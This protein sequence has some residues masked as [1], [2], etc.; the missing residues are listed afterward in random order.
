MATGTLP[1]GFNGLQYIASYPDLIQSLG[2]NRAAGEQH[3]LAVGQAE[4]RATDT[5]DLLR[6]LDNNPDVEAA[7]GT[8][9]D[10]ATIHYIRQGF[11]EGRTD[12]PPAGLPPGFNGLQYIASYPDLIQSLGADRFAGE[13]HYLSCGQAEGRAP[14]TFDLARYL[15]NNPDV[16]AAFGSNS[17]AATIHYIEQGFFEGRTDDPPAGPAAPLRRP[18]IH[19]VLSR[20]DPG[21]RRRPLRRRAALPRRWA[22]RGPPDRYLRRGALPGQQPRPEGRARYQQHRPP[23]RT[24]SSSGFAE[25]RTDDP[26]PGLP[27][28]FSGLQ[29]I[30]SYPDLIEAIGADRL[31][32]E[33]HYLQAGQAEG[34]AA[35]HLQHSAIPRE[36]PGRRGRVRQQRRCGHRYTSS[37]MATS[38]AARMMRRQPAQAA[39]DF[40]F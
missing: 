17:S 8:S 23:P 40:L 33:Q 21:A 16:A 29:Y 38:K 12:D 4:G 5:F 28:G 13:Q 11:F 1:P 2:A 31:A 27:P 10:G 7:F 32:G 15:D 3:Y 22:G 6:Y 36:L 35:R 37:S 9:G 18:A 25:G 26:P 39:T 30:A 14:D 34:R 24:T 20:P 19:R